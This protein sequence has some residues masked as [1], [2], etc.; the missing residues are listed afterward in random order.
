MIEIMIV[1]G[2]AFVVSVICAALGAW[3]GIATN[4]SHDDLGFGEGL[5]LL[6]GGATG[7]II[8]CFIGS[9]IGAALVT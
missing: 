5:S 2:V 6:F 3:I 9:M 4:D 8:G 1:V 7:A